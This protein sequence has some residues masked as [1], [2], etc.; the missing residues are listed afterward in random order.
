MAGDPSQYV[1]SDMVVDTYAGPNSTFL[2]VT[3]PS[4]LLGYVAVGL[5]QYGYQVLALPSLVAQLLHCQC[6]AFPP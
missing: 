6:F 5:L 1:S 3:Q 2:E 4:Q